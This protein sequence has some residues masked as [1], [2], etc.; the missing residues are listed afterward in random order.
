M[1]DRDMGFVRSLK[2]EQAR[3]ENALELAEHQVS[4]FPVNHKRVR[5]LKEIRAHLDRIDRTIKEAE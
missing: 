5:S 2:A 1:K 3:L 4:R